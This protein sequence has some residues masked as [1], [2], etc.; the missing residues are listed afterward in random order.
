MMLYALDH[1][2]FQAFFIPFSSRHSVT[3]WSYFQ[4]SKECFSRS[5]LAF[6]DFFLANLALFASFV[7]A[8]LFALVKSSLDCRLWQRHVYLLESV[9]H[10]T[11]CFSL[12][13]SGFSDHPLLLSSVDVQVFLCCW[14]HQCVLFFSECT[15]LLI[16]SLRMFLLS[17]WWIC[18]TCMESS[19][20]CM[21]CVH[22]SFRMQMAHLELTPDLLPA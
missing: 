7:E 5:A 18:F 4:P 2:L 10:L 20:G 11:G 13:W 12:P 19:F 8:F 21:M 1:E 22:N 17:L 14:A 16:W 15:K 9:L 6:L 3:G